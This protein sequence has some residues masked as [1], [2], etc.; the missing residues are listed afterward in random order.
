V[1][2]LLLS[3]LLVCATGLYTRD[4]RGSEHPAPRAGFDTLPLSLGGYEGHEAPPFSDDVLAQLGADDYVNRY[5]VSSSAAPIVVYAGYYATQR[6][7]DA[8]HSP[9]NCLPG[10]GWIPIS[11]E[12]TQMNVGGQTVEVNRVIIE[13]GRTRQAVMYWYQGRGRVTANEFVNKGWLMLDAARL[14]RT[15]GGLV[16][17]ITP[18]SDSR[19]DGFARLGAFASTLIPSLWTHLP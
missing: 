7:G 18:L 2:R 4:A 11:S 10:A 15:D 14:R 12:R 8:I 19:D 13:K 6:Q 17:L 1:T 3:L 16:R 5:Y 9:Q